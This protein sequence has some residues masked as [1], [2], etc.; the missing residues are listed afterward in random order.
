MMNKTKGPEQGNL[1]AA[2]WLDYVATI[3]KPHEQIK[4]TRRGGERFH[5]F[6]VCRNGVSGNFVVEGL[7]Q[8]NL[9]FAKVVR[10]AFVLSEP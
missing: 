8:A 10:A 6:E 3:G 7:A 1:G 5:R 2:A 4:G 9:V